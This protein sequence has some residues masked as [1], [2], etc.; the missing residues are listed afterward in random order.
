MPMK[1][2]SITHKVSSSACGFVLRAA[3]FFPFHWSI[4]F[5]LQKEHVPGALLIVTD[6]S[7]YPWPKR[8]WQ[9][10]P[11]APHLQQAG[12]CGGPAAEAP[13]PQSAETF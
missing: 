3:I 9:Q 2:V 10:W 4:V 12:G 7:G 11:G 6:D 1:L 5:E 8:Q 13:P